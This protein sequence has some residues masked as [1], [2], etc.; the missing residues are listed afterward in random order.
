MVML[1]NLRLWFENP[2]KLDP[3]IYLTKWQIGIEKCKSISRHYLINNFSGLER[4][5][6][7]P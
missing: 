7:S 3:G 4:G 1:V 2:Q 6:K 5:G